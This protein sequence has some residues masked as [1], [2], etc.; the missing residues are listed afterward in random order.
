VIIISTYVPNVMLATSWTKKTQL[1]RFVIAVVLNVKT[2]LLVQ[3]ANQTSGNL[4]QQKCANVRQD[5]SSI[6]TSKA[7]S[8]ADP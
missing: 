8:L 4:T 7:A 5:T 1:A 3:S 6:S 2:Q